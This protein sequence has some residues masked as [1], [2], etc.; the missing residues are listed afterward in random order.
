[1]E[2][3]SQRLAKEEANYISTLGWLSTLSVAITAV[4]ASFV[5]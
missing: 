5:S 4:A 3:K 2:V 1:M